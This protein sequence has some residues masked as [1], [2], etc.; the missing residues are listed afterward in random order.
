[1]LQVSEAVRSLCWAPKSPGKMAK[2]F[3]LWFWS[4]GSGSV[5]SG[6]VDAVRKWP[7]CSSK[8]AS[9]SWGEQVIQTALKVTRFPVPPVRQCFRSCWSSGIF[10]TR[11]SRLCGERCRNT[12]CCVG[13]RKK[14]DLVDGRGRRRMTR[15]LWDERETAVAQII[16]C[17]SQGVQ[18]T[19]FEDTLG[20]LKQMGCSSSKKRK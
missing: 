8:W 12:K 15:L 19:A 4:R 2:S 20:I 14:K 7:G 9:E 3:W 10:H 11:P 5:Y 18:T 6:F 13:K 16:A 17:Y 1:M